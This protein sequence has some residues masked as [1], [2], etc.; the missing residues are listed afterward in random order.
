MKIDGNQ[1]GDGLQNGG[2]LIIRKGGE[3]L[4]FHKEEVPGDH[5]DND[6]ILNTLGITEEKIRQADI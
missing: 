2:M 1:R 5:V 6:I 3:L 4:L